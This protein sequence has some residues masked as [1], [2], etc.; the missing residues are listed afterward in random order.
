MVK[1]CFLYVLLVLYVGMAKSQAFVHPGINQ[2]TADLS[3]IKQLVLAGTQPY[4]AA[5]DQLKTAC[6]TGFNYQPYAHVL[7]GP[8]GNPNIGGN[9]LLQ[10]AN[11]AY[12]YALIWYITNNKKYAQKAIAILDKWSAT[13]WHFDYNDAKLLA[14]WTG[15]LLCNAAEILRYT[16]SG[17]QPPQVSR[18]SAVLTTVYYPL[19]RFYFPQANGNWDGAIIHSIAAIAIFTDN[20][21]MFNNAVDHYLH[22]AVNGSVFKYIYP[23]GQCQE[24]ARDQAH[25]QLGL[26]EFAGAAQVAYTQG[27]DL[28]LAGNNRLA[29]GYEYTAGFLLGNDPHAYGIKSERAKTLRDDYEY[30]YRHYAYKGVPIP[31]TKQAADSVR[32]K[33]WRSTLTSVRAAFQQK[34]VKEVS[35]QGSAIGSFAGASDIIGNSIKGNVIPVNVGDNVQLAIN[36]AAKNGSGI[37]LKHGIHI[38]PES[39]QIPSNITISGEGL[40]TILWLKASSADRDVLLNATPGLQNVII[41]NLVVECSNKTDRGTDPNNSRSLRGG[42]NRGGII[43]RGN[44][45]GQMQNIIL[46]NVTVQNATYNGVYISGADSVTIERC[47]FTENGGSVVPGPRLQHNLLLTHCRQVKV[48]SSRLDTSPFGAGISL[49]ECSGVTIHDNEV[50]RNAYYGLVLAETNDVTITNNLFEANDRSGVMLQYLMNG[51]NRIIVTGNRMQYNNGYGIEAY[52]ATQT[53]VAGNRYEGNGNNP[54]QEKISAEKNIV[55]E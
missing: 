50:A 11:M 39:L 44:T 47:D 36:T 52:A 55:M 3:T 41:Q 49:E 37:L 43:F 42:Y 35:L 31:F 7:R 26:G 34:Q 21:P 4:K 20:R 46:R 28:F 23:S 33:S 45:L 51:C 29:L 5:F 13:L 54:V 2:T 38:L 24:T 32:P 8:Y 14:A 12:N 40:G 19:M 18:F 16:P 27:V 1:H 48:V 9:E 6:D 53:K 22:G 30:V 15:H 25:V 17:W 10:S